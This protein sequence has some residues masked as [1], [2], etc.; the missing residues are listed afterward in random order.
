MKANIYFSAIAA[1]A[2]V[3]VSGCG[4]DS[5]GVGVGSGSPLDLPSLT[6]NFDGEYINISG[7]ASSGGDT[8]TIFSDGKATLHR[9]GVTYTG[10]VSSYQMSVSD[11]KGHSLSG[12]ISKTGKYWTWNYMENDGSKGVNPL[13]TAATSTNLNGTY[14]GTY[15][16]STGVTG[17]TLATIGSNALV[18]AS[19]TPSTGGAYGASGF[20]DT[21]GDI[22]LY[23]Y[24]T[25]TSSYQIAVGPTMLSGMMLTGTLSEMPSGSTLTLSE[26]K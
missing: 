8:L 2:T 24:N 14:S 22:F 21:S 19:F 1:L 26:T 15:K 3:L 5:G 6:G 10:T 23:Y 13:G 4:G 12:T 25:S 17:T 20:V 11:G 7:S 9:N 18:G 16:S